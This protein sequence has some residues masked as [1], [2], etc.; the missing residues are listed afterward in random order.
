LFLGG[1]KRFQLP[2]EE[3]PSGVLTIDVKGTTYNEFRLPKQ[4][5]RTPDHIY[6]LIQVVEREHAFFRGYAFGN[7][8]FEEHRKK[9]YED[10]PGYKPKVV[11]ALPALEELMRACQFRRSATEVGT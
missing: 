6:V 4:F 7:D 9:S 5:I 2:C 1:Q 3:M 8:E 11:R 10:Q